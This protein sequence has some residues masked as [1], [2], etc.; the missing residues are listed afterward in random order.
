MAAQ[1]NI[2]YT[3]DIFIRTIV[4]ESLIKYFNLAFDIVEIDTAKEQFAKEFPI[5]T[6]PS[7]VTTDGNKFFEQLAIND[8]LIN[9]S[10]NQEEINLLLGDANDLN[11]RTE[12]AM[13]ASFSGSDY[14]N[15]LAVYVKPYLGMLP[16]VKK[17]EENTLAK[18]AVMDSFYEGKLAHQKYLT[19]DHITVADLVTATSM[20]LGFAVVYGKEWR[21]E[22]KAISEWFD[23][24]IH[25]KYLESHFKDFK[26]VDASASLS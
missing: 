6:V 20:K 19:G 9:S 26:Y 12:I 21:A 24:V 3:H 22:H 15:M 2:L 1:K 8:Y 25:S 7:I 13:I 16:Y 4:P 11:H 14:L 5:K 17:T 18:L 10:K 23:R